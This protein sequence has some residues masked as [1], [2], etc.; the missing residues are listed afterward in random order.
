MWRKW[1]N[2]RINGITHKI[3]F[4]L[5]TENI[6]DNCLAVQ[7]VISVPANF[8][9]CRL[10]VKILIHRSR[11]SCRIL[12]CGMSRPYLSFRLPAIR[13]MVLHPV[14][15]RPSTVKKLTR[16]ILTSWTN[17]FVALKWY[18]RR[19]VWGWSVSGGWCCW[20]RKCSAEKCDR[21]ASESRKVSERTMLRVQHEVSTYG[22]RLLPLLVRRPGTVF[23]T[24]SA[25]Q[26]PP[27]LLSGAF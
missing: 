8:V 16:N 2:C 21:V 5:K 25:I 26:T 27:K 13:E 1:W 20:A 19:C 6:D 14:S 17:C 23:W 9:I 22:P 12:F 18:F 24:L 7:R 10:S 11:L 4:Q 3:L 15:C